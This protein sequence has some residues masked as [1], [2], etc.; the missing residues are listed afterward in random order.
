MGWRLARFHSRT[1]PSASALASSLPSGLN[2][3]A[4]TPFGLLVAWR[5]APTG[6]PVA[7]FHSRTVPSPSAL[8]SSLPS[9]L[10][11]TARTVDGSAGSMPFCCCSPSKV[12]MAEPAWAVGKTRQAATA[13]CRA[14]TGLVEA[15]ARLSAASWRD[16]A[17]PCCRVALAALCTAIPAAVMAI[18]VRTRR[19]AITACRRRTVRRWARL[20]ACRKS[21]SV[22]LSGGWRAGSAPIRAAVSVAACQQAAAVE[23]G[24]VAGVAGP[25]G[26]GGVQPGADDPVGV[27]FGQP[28]VAQQRPGGQQRLVADLHGVGGQG[29]QPF[30]GEGLQHRLHVLGLGWALALGQFRPG[31]AVGAV[32]TL[33]A[34]GGQPQEHLPGRGL[35]GRGEAVVDALGAGGDGAFDAAGAFIVGQGEGLPG[36]AAPGLVQGVRQQRQHPRAEGPGLAGAHLGQQDLDQVVIDAGVCLLGR[37]GDGHPQLP[38]GH[39]RDQV[40]VLDRVGQLRVVRAAGLE[41]G[42]HP[43]HDQRRRCLIRAV[44]GGGGRVQRGDERPPLPLVGAL[45]EQ[46]LELVDHQQQPPL[47]RGL[48][49]LRPRGHRSPPPARLAAPGRPAGR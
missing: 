33:A 9:G 32:H 37:F 19:P 4:R 7:R 24:R 16:R 18:R 26:G 47:R 1:V 3:T 8:A 46:L 14:I 6:W 2:A 5:G 23:V 36:P 49:P 25:V 30:G 22:W 38:L 21:R 40:A 12:V 11:A 48:I 28:G 27:G 41:V 45:G 43:Q 35:L 20:L 44:S 13:S 34:G 39:R 15:R 10:N 17:R 29:E 31:G 42:A